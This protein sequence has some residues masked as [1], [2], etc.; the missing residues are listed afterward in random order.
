MPEPGRLE[1]AVAVEAIEDAVTKVISLPLTKRLSLARTLAN[2]GVSGG[3][4]YDGLIAFT[5][6]H[7]E[8]TLLT[9]DGRAVPTYRACGARFELLTE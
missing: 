8:A 3:A 7:H 2:H 6:A 9:L 1:P 4:S 5:A